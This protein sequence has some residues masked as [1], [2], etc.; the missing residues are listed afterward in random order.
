[1]MEAAKKIG[2]VLVLVANIFFCSI[3]EAELTGDDE[4]QLDVLSAQSRI[5]EKEMCLEE[6]IGQDG[7][8]VV[9]D[10]DNNGR[11]E[12]LFQTKA[13]EEDCI[14]V[15]GYEV[16]ENGDGVSR[17]RFLDGT[18]DA[19]IAKEHVRMYFACQLGTRHYIFQSSRWHHG[20]NGGF[21][22]SGE[23]LAL[24]LRQGDVT[25]E[26][27]GR[28]REIYNDRGQ[29]PVKTV[30]FN[31]QGKALSKA[32]YEKLAREYYDGCHLF[33]VTLGWRQIGEL[34]KAMDDQKKVRELFADSWKDF[35]A[36]E[37]DEGPVHK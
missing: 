11:L 22:R 21:E 30:Y 6:A 23:M 16:T 8:F 28:Y 19:E 4:Q 2:L 33:E 31:A 34:A 37:I 25:G 3:A 32:A 15:W 36:E 26:L 10:L 17:L 20:K 27:L 7:K 13:G 24:C 12:L 35:H 29:L 1:M 14:E 5:W 9:A 18:G